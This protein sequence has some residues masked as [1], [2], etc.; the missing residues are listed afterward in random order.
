M[1]AWA[2]LW[3]R[4]REGQALVEYGL[5]LILASVA[6]LLALHFLG[7]VTEHSL[8]NTAGMVNSA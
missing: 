2:K 7:G 1:A 4:A 3:L 5:I 6:A 8:N